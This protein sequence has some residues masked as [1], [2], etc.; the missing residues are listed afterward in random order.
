MADTFEFTMQMDQDTLEYL[1]ERA[2]HNAA[3]GKGPDTVEGV[4]V[5]EIRYAMN[6]RKALA[7]D[8]DKPAEAR[9]CRHVPAGE[10]CPTCG[11]E[12]RG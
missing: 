7:K 10:V 12:G 1:T 11:R 3:R 2:A 8:K 4:A 5:E 6:R 9:R